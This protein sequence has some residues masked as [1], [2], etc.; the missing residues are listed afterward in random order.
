MEKK[1]NKNFLDSLFLWKDHL[2]MFEESFIHVWVELWWRDQ[3]FVLV[4][5]SLS[6]KIIIILEKDVAFGCV[7]IGYLRRYFCEPLSCSFFV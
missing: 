2:E 4:F 7:S 3:G 6:P 1:N 5:I